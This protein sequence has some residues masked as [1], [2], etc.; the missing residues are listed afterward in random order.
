MLAIVPVRAVVPATRWPIAN[1][2]ILGAMAVVSALAW[3]HHPEGLLAPSHQGEPTAYQRLVLRDGAPVELVGHVLVHT[4]PLHLAGTIVFLWVFG[5]AVCATVGN[6]TYTAVFLASAALTGT[7]HV[8]GNGA[9][10][11]GAGGAT[12][13]VVGLY[14]VLHLLAPVTCA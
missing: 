13:G 9:P 6:L 2:L 8:H 1:V 12:S 4:D 3:V 5:N 10:V 7:I 14:L 11:I